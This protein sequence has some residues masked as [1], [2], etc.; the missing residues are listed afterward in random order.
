MARSGPALAFKMHSALTRHHMASSL[1]LYLWII[2]VGTC[3]LLTLYKPKE[4]TEEED[5]AQSIPL[6]FLNPQEDLPQLPLP[7]VT[8]GH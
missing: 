5:V 8:R 7:V 1:F 3:I 2:P 4:R 6:A